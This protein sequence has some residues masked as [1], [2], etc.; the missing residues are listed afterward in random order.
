VGEGGVGAR[1]PVPLVCRLCAGEMGEETD[2]GMRV[3]ACDDGAAPVRELDKEGEEEDG[4]DKAEKED[5]VF[6]SCAGA[7]PYRCRLS[8]THTCTHR[9]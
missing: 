5:S 8:I 3:C 1:K 2:I 7:D 9:F 6:G 4:E